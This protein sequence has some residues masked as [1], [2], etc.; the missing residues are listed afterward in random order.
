MGVASGTRGDAPPYYKKIEGKRSADLSRDGT[1]L[2]AATGI[3]EAEARL[4]LVRADS[5]AQEKGNTTLHEV[6]PAAMVVEL[7][8][9]EDLQYVLFHFCANVNSL[10]RRRKFM[11]RYD[12]AARTG[13]VRLT[14]TQEREMLSRRSAIR[15]RLT[16]VRAVQAIYTPCVPAL[17]AAHLRSSATA[18]A[19]RGQ[20]DRIRGSR[21][22][23]A[24]LPSVLSQRG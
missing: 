8:E 13:T 16:T 6:T 4:Q 10:F 3:T 7:L 11:R 2:T 24:P 23:R 17:V 19:S 1:I 12:S 15:R 9:I 22:G 14:A 18:T 5:E 21:R 20:S